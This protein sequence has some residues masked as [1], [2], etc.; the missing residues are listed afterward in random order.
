MDFDPV[1]VPDWLGRSA[2]RWPDKVGLVAGGQR[3]TYQELDELS[4]RLAAGFVRLGL[5]KGQRVIIWLG[6]SAET[7][8]AIYGVL[9][10]GGVFVVLDIKT[11]WSAVRNVISDAAASFLLVSGKKS[12]DKSFYNDSLA[13]RK[14]AGLKIIMAGAEEKF[15]AQKS[16]VFSFQELCRTSPSGQSRPLILENDL[17]CLIYTSGSTG[18]PKGIM[19]TH[20][21]IISAARSIIQY[22]GNTAEDVIL[23]ILPLSFDYGLYQVFMCFMFGGRLVLEPSFAYLQDILETIERE[24][25]TGF[26]IIPSISAM[27]LKLKSFPRKQLSTLRY[28]TNT[29]A[30]W[31]VSHIRQLRQMLPAVK[32]FSMYG[33]SE[34][35]RVSYLP[36]ELIDEFPESVGRPMPN[37]EI[38]I[39]D[40]WGRPVPPGKAGQLIVRGPSVMQ[41]Y[42]GDKKL[43]ARVFRPGKYPEDR[44]LFTGDL[45]HQDEHGLLYFHGRKDRQ[46]KS[47]GHRLNLVEVEK[48][49]SGLDKITEVAAVPVPD[50]I[51]GTVVGVFVVFQKGA[52]LSENQLRQYCQRHLEP[53]KVPR[54]IWF[55]KSLPK[56]TTGKVDYK[57]L[58]QMAEEMKAGG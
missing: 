3:L 24:K 14:L 26:P 29:G 33:L 23:N 40:R 48:V 5:K 58:K 52:A 34:C 51:G 1:L 27:L 36:P 32:L 50:E 15:S 55:R 13:D 18:K 17:A 6:N 9:K 37:L 45:F 28:I 42:W 46:I 16:N 43:T 49:I 22:L 8:L 7:V 19:C 11:P 25:V 57:K 2:A 44:W 12:V 47:F 38:A 31:P 20:H 56:T 35:K 53:Y 4:S 41:G 21:N 39:I 54:H 30:T 10:A